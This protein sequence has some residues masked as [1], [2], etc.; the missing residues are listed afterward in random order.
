LYHT[1]SSAI[2]PQTDCGLAVAP[3]VVP[4]IGVQFVLA[5]RTIAPVVSSFAGGGIT[6]FT[7]MEK[8]PL[9]DPEPDPELNTLIRYVEEG[10][11][12][13]ATTDSNEL[14]AAFLDPAAPNPVVSK[15]FVILEGWIKSGAAND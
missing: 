15:V 11:N 7:Q 10:V 3:N 5:V 12:P 2:P 4:V 8:A 13:L 14:D 1:S 6:S 9:V